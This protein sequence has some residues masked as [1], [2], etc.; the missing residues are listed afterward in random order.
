M[1]DH[2][3][4]NTYISPGIS[5]ERSFIRTSNQ[6]VMDMVITLS[7]LPNCIYLL[8]NRLLFEFGNF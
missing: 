8:I 5:R 3:Q 4:N 7:I 2:D 6:Q 1:A